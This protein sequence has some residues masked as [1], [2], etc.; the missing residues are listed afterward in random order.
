M[1]EIG[2]FYHLS[3]EVLQPLGFVGSWEISKEQHV[4]VIRRTFSNNGKHDLSVLYLGTATAK[5][6]LDVKDAISE[7]GYASDI[8]VVDLASRPLRKLHKKDSTVKAIKL[9]ACS[10]PFSDS[11]FDVVTTD[12]LFNMCSLEQCEKIV[13][14]IGR[15]LTPDGVTTMTVFTK[16]N[17]VNNAQS[18]L[19]NNLSRK[20]FASEWDWIRV[21]DKAGMNLDIQVFKARRKPFLYHTDHFTQLIARRRI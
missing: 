3:Y 14:E 11:S 4:D 13:G 19:I 6:P 8:T 9:D 15:V 21:F 10:V 16:E 5:N 20:H 1:A 12:F 7:L 17:H 2:K 18:F